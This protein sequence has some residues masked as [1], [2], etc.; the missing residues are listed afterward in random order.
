MAC[1][2]RAHCV[3]PTLF[4]TKLSNPAPGTNIIS[5][6]NTFLDTETC[7]TGTVTVRLM[8]A[9]HG[10]HPSGALRASNFVPGKVVDPAPGTNIIISITSTFLDTETCLTGTVTVRLMQAGRKNCRQQDCK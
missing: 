7:L 5:I 4:L 3:R 1:T 9:V 6:I 10:L 2:L 8:Q